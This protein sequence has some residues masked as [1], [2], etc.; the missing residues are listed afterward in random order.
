MKFNTPLYLIF[1]V[2][3]GT[4]VF[5]QQPKTS[6]IEGDKS[7]DWNF[8][9]APY[10]LFAAQSTDVGGEKIRQSFNDLTSITNSGFQLIGG[11]QYKKWTAYMDGTFAH[12]SFDETKS[13]L[14]LELKIV[15]TILDLRLGYNIYENLKHDKNE[16]I[17]GWTVQLNSGAKYW[18]NDL[19][20]DYSIGSG[21][22]AITGSVDEIQRWWDLMF[23]ARFNFILSPKVLLGV[24]GSIGGF[25]IGNSN[26]FSHDFTYSNS[27]IIKKY[28]WINAG[29]R[30][31]KYKRTDGT[32]ENEIKTTV[33][34][35][36]PLIGVTFR[37]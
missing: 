33:H 17:K 8:Y 9:V 27:F 34:V 21:N 1:T 20:I 11:V 15:Q 32:G 22:N 28:I 29:F 25:G 35:L 3:F 26:D 36:G 18:R 16:I 14:N 5:A 31:F 37:I 12:L 23:G 4:C 19:G 30:S 13:I 6:S 24:S 10:V 7:K 2:L